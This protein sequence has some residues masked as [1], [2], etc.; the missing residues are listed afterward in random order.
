MHST[1]K[2]IDDWDA[3]A[4]GDWEFLINKHQPYV[5][6]LARRFGA[7]EYETEDV[8]QNTWMYV[9]K[10]F[11]GRPPKFRTGVFT[12][13]LF[14]VVRNAVNDFYNK[15]A[16]QRVGGVASDFKVDIEQRGCDDLDPMQMMMKNED[17]EGKKELYAAAQKCL[18]KLSK[19]CLEVW[20][21]AQAGNEQLKARILESMNGGTYRSIVCRCRKLLRQCVEGSSQR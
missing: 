18:T 10:R 11:D 16:K 1:K 2:R 4:D 6:K 8:E 14:R 17:L 15:A 3:V 21:S 19:R 12:T 13:Y 9:M 7:A 20:Q 5:N